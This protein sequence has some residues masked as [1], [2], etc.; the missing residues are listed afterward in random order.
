MKLSGPMHKIIRKNKNLLGWSMSYMFLMA[1]SYRSYLTMWYKTSKH[2]A[3]YIFHSIQESSGYSL[4]LHLTD[5]KF[6]NEKSFLRF[7]TDTFVI[8]VPTMLF[9]PSCFQ[10]RMKNSPFLSLCRPAHL[11]L[12][13]LHRYFSP[14][15]TLIPV[16]AV[17][18]RF[19]VNYARANI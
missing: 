18:Y 4:H 11:L 9:T 2:E 17:V 13:L 3:T 8:S 7:S 14:L 10:R 12:M 1:I 16:C 15:M 5:K 19:V 6:L